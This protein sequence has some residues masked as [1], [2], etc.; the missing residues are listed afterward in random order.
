MDESRSTALRADAS[1]TVL[2]CKS[3]MTPWSRCFSRHQPTAVFWSWS[4]DM[5][6]P[7]TN[8][9]QAPKGA[10]RMGY[11]SPSC[12]LRLSS[13]RRSRSHALCCNSTAAAERCAAAAAA[14]A[15]GAA[16]AKASQA[17]SPTCNAMVLFLLSMSPS[18]AGEDASPALL[19]PQRASSPA[20]FASN[21]GGKPRPAVPKARTTEGLQAACDR[22][23][24]GERNGNVD[25]VG[26]PRTGADVVR[27]RPAD[28]GGTGQLPESTEPRR[29]GKRCW[30]AAHNL[31]TSYLLTPF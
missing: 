16:A 2:L 21:G 29:L 15:E 30:G 17:L 12:S 8:G 4:A 26:S 27:R 6:E 19:L 11:G 25:A 1:P 22:A 18:H 31:S 28:A 5:V 23:A 9:P 24:P 13:L 3:D 10:T 14:A 20:I 7:K